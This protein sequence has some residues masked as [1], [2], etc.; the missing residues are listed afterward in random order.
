MK[1]RLVFA[2]ALVLAASAAHAQ[3]KVTAEL[4]AQERVATTAPGEK[5]ALEAGMVAQAQGFAFARV[6]LESKIVKGAPYSAEIVTESTQQL[7]DGNRIVRKSTG[8]V[9]RDS[10]GRTRRE[11]D[12]EP[13]RIAGISIIDPVAQFAYSLDASTKTAWKTPAGTANVLVDKIQGASL[14]PAEIERRQKVETEMTTAARAGGAG[15]AAPAGTMVATGALRPTMESA[16]ARL[17]REGRDA[18]R[19][20]YRRRDGRRE[21][22]DAHHS[23][24]RRRQRTADRVGH[25]RM[26]LGGT[27]VARDDAHLGSAHGRVRLPPPEHHARRAERLVVRGAGGLHDQGKRRAQA[28][29]LE[30]G[31]T[32]R[33]A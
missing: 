30:V 19:Q 17:G 21:A 28:P 10:Q 7:P 22:H 24:R 26:A 4:I 11:D 25:R 8:R 33:S 12:I 2:G 3:D 16:G 15:G 32:F 1:S 31:R 23:R 9:Y 5:R 18:A 6:P 14:D 29:A 27:S 20:E 13:G